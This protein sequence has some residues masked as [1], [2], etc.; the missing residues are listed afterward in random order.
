MTLNAK[1]FQREDRKP[2]PAAQPHQLGSL[3]K[4][5][6]I[7]S[8]FLPLFGGLGSWA[9]TFSPASPEE[10]AV[11]APVCWAGKAV[12]FSLAVDAKLGFPTALQRRS[13]SNP[14]LLSLVNR[15]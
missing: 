5:L 12:S 4:P 1:E 7:R 10:D 3:P 11:G 8:A 15:Y 9:G 6:P 13:F 14:P 2:P